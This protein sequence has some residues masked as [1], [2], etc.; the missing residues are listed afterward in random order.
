M[1]R[2]MSRGNNAHLEEVGRKS[3]SNERETA[4]RYKWIG[5]FKRKRG[6]SVLQE[7]VRGNIHH[8]C[9]QQTFYKLHLSSHSLGGPKPHTPHTFYWQSSN[10]SH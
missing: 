2:N 10:S 9:S 1:R 8:S 6:V 5:E 4:E 7:E 3:G